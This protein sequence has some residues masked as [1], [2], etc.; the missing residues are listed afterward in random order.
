MPWRRHRR[1]LGFRPAPVA[2]TRIERAAVRLVDLED[3]VVLRVSP[4]VVSEVA[5]VF[6][7]DLR[8]CH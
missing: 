2:D 7:N 3:L 5:V 4:L 1:Q 6:G 8:N